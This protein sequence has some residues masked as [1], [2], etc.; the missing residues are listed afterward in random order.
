MSPIDHVGCRSSDRMRDEL[1]ALLQRNDSDD[2]TLQSFLQKYGP[3][4]GA[5]PTTSG[6]NR[7]AWIMPY[8]M[9]VLATTL[10]MLTVH[11]WRMRPLASSPCYDASVADQ[12]LERFRDQARRDTEI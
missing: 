2:L 3:M 1:V 5:A 9:L 6:F 12:T 11:S 10:V 4:V 7:V 8:L